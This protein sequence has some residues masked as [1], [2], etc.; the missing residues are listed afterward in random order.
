M[1]ADLRVHGARVHTPGG[2][3]EADVLVRGGVVAG[4]VERSDDTSARETFDATGLDVLPGLVDLHAH[5]R[6]PGLS[7]KE[8]FRTV[9]AAAAAGGI[10]AY[11]DM[12][13]VEP[14]TDSA[15][16]LLE[17]RAMAA[18]D[19]IVDWGHFASGSRPERVA[20]LAAAGATGF[21]IFMVSGGYPHDDRIAVSANDRLYEAME[22]IAPTGLPLLVHPFDQALFDMFWRRLLATGRAPDHTA[23]IEVYTGRDIVWRSAIATLLEFQKDTGVRLQVLHTHATGSLEMIRRAKAEGARVTAALDL[24]YFHLTRA[25]MERLGPR[26]YSGAVVTDDPKRM[27]AIWEAVHDGTLD[28]IDSDHAPHLLEEVEVARVDASKAQLGSPQ[29]DDML[30]VLLNDVHLGRL[31]LGDIARM[32]SENP[33]RLIGRYPQKGAVLPGSD[34]DLV[35]VDTTREVELRDENVKTKVGWTPYHGWKVVGVPV[36]TVSRGAVVA[37]EGEVVGIPGHGR[38]MEGRPLRYAPV[39]TAKSPGLALEPMRRGD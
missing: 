35:V 37:R 31:A 3:V 19:S 33:A 25:D 26:S 16:L 11:V 20:E 4:L 28:M 14:P 29:Y 8:D 36:L 7:H 38:Y 21:K 12:P 18:R 13:N 30:A 1:T 17:K 2:P 39:G 22:A 32:V 6:T 5:T 24:K 9:S 27:T 15:D 23:R 10:T 34:A